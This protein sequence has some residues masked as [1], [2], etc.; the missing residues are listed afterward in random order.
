MSTNQ[1]TSYLV[2]IIGS[3]RGAVTQLFARDAREAER[4][5]VASGLDWFGES[6]EAIAFD[7]NAANGMYFEGDPTYIRSVIARANT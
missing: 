2:A 5:G 4:V 6:C 3:K 7:T 1:R